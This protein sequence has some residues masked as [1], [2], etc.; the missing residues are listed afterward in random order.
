MDDAQDTH[1]HVCDQVVPDDYLLTCTVMRYTYVT[2]EHRC[3]PDPHIH[4]EHLVVWPEYGS[5]SVD[6][7]GEIWRVA[8]GQGIWIPA[9]TPHAITR[10]PG[11]PLIALHILPSAWN[12]LIDAPTMMV[13]NRALREMLLYLAFTGMHKERRL[14]AQVV[15]LELL[16]EDTYPVVKV[17]VPRDPRI[18]GIMQ[19]I[20]D[21]PADDRTI[22]E[23]AWL[24]STSTRTIARA[25]KTETGMTFTQWR[26]NVRMASAVELLGAGVTVTQVTRKVGYSNVSAFS[27]A[28]KRTTGR[29]PTDFIQT[30][31]V[32]H[33]IRTSILI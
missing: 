28:F 26:T 27:T 1:P 17:P 12:K 25:F 14:R 33:K 6:I 18:T 29:H 4:P 30:P 15:C 9:G 16:A 7:D 32:N 21:D 10:D 22:E 23:W 11:N 31:K 13:V 5:G 3:G 2:D 19:A 8:L 24:T 20:I